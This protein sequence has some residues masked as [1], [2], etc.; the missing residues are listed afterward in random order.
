MNDISHTETEAMT[1]STEAAPL[2]ISENAAR[3]VAEI[4]T[5]EGSPDAML[6]VTVSGGGCSGFQYGFAFDTETGDDDVI[7]SRDDIKVVTDSMSLLY[8][9]G[10]EIDFV[11]DLIGAAFTIRNPNATASCSC[12]SSFAVG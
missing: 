2:T 11:E 5:K 1:G 4:R 3:R 6:R 9:A 8:M 12:G 10:S 7:V